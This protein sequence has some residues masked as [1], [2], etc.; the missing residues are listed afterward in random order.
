MNELDLQKVALSFGFTAP[1]SVNLSVT[2]SGKGE[3]VVRR[4][5]GGG[6]GAGYKNKPDASADKAKLYKSSNLKQAD[7]SGRQW[8]R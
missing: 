4:G 2:S 6:F 8:S 7:G 1:P 5:G 3:K